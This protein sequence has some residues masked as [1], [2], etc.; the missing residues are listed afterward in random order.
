MQYW[1]VFVYAMQCVSQRTKCKS[2]HERSEQWEVVRKKRCKQN[3]KCFHYVEN[4]V[5]RSLFSRCCCCCVANACCFGYWLFAFAI[6]TRKTTHFYSI[7]YLYEHKQLHFFVILYYVEKMVLLS[8][9]I[10]NEK[11]RIRSEKKS[12]VN[13]D[14]KNQKLATKDEMKGISYSQLSY[15]LFWNDEFSCF[16]ICLY[17]NQTKI[18]CLSIEFLLVDY[19]HS[20]VCCRK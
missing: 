7:F 16:C 10:Q 3:R 14:A 20:P 11:K 2:E 8:Y 9:L 17:N 5:I 4:L 18:L 1:C 15:I 13:Y 19:A 12:N 6:K